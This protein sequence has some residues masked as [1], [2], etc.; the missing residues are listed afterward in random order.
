VFVP[1]RRH[2]GTIGCLSSFK[3]DD[4]VGPFRFAKIRPSFHHLATFLQ[5]VAATVG[6][7]G[8]VSDDMRQRRLSLRRL[9]ADMSATVLLSHN[10][11]S[12]KA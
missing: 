6:L 4:V 8:L 7:L 1:L 9:R 12:P 11:H 10:Y 5:C 2:V 3:G